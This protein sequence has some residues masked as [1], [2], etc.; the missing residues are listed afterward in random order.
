M[1]HRKVSRGKNWNRDMS[2]RPMNRASTWSKK[3]QSAKVSRREW[4]N[5]GVH[6]A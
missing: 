2:G 5:K 1:K 3:D 6:D 4:K